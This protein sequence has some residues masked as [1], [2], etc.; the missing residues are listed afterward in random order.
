MF[1]VGA[2]CG[3]LDAQLSG[4]AAP[5]ATVFLAI[6]LTRAQDS[7]DASGPQVG[8]WGKVEAHRELKAD[9]RYA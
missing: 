7:N 3:A 9:G 1:K 2:C 4:Y 8:N 5:A 6:L